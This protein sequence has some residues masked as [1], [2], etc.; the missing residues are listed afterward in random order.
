[1]SCTLVSGNKT[2]PFYRSGVTLQEVRLGLTFNKD[3]KELKEGQSLPVLLH[4]G[5]GCKIV[6]KAEPLPQAKNCVSPLSLSPLLFDSPTAAETEDNVS[7][8]G[9]GNCFI[10]GEAD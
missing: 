8:G 5:P 10:E 6:P 3:L 2:S 9:G 7:G 4:M 1:V